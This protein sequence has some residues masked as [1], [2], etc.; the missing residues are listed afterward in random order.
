MDTPATKLKEKKRLLDQRKKNRS[1]AGCV[2]SHTSESYMKL[3]MEIET[4]EEEIAE[5]EK[6]A[7]EQ[8]T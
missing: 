2:A 5:L 4:L 6:A 3:E 7:G 1:T 8:S